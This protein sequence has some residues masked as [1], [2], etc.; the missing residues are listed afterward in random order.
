MLTEN[1]VRRKVEDISCSEALPMRKVR[2]LLR[3]ARALK[4]QARALHHARALSAPPSDRNTAAHLDRVLRAL[5]SLYEDVRLAALRFIKAR[6][7][8]TLSFAGGA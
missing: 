2:G 5:R 1:E 6:P 8:V 3:L 4:L 7:S